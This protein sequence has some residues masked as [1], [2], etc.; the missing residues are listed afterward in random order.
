MKKL[1][2][3]IMV[4]MDA[5]EAAALQAEWDVWFAA[6]PARDAEDARKAKVEAA[7]A[8]DTVVAQ[9][10]AMTNAEF[11]AWFAANV[12]NLTQAR[13]VLERLARIIIRRVL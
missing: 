10:Q 4:D 7:I 5:Q 13:N 6:K 12:T 2:N 8:G 11:S 3:G 1:V 9:L